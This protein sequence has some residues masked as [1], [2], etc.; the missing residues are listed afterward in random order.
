[1]WK[2]SVAVNKVSM[3]NK[4][5]VKYHFY[6]LY[7]QKRTIVMEN[8]YNPAEQRL[9]LKKKDLDSFIIVFN[10]LSKRDDITPLFW[11]YLP[12]D[13]TGH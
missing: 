4:C 5:Y 11:R 2:S 8:M 9:K 13:K 10:S 6:N 3:Y 1:M 7:T 12:K